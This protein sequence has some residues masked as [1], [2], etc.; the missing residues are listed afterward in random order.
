MYLCVDVGRQI[1]TENGECELAVRVQTTKFCRMVA[2]IPNY[3]KE[4]YK[5][6][7]EYAIA[8]ANAGR[9]YGVKN[10]TND[11]AL[12]KINDYAW[13]KEQYDRL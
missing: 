7:G 10:H 11:K 2:K 5:E 3:L 13:L 9:E 12:N 1:F 8:G 4:P 6:F